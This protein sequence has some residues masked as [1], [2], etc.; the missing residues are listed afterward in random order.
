MNT[1]KILLILM[2]TTTVA[3]AATCPL[4]LNDEVDPE[5]TVTVLG[6]KL[7]FCCGS[8]VTK[9]EENTAYYIKVLEPLSKLFTEAEKKELKVCCVKPLDQ[10]YCP[11]YPDRLIN[12]NSP[13]VEYNGKKIYLW[14]SSAVRR[15]KRDPEKYYNS[16]LDSGIIK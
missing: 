9:F 6:K 13:V 7:E 14:S 10:R 5:E 12:P 4:M 15:W 16:G 1:K 8:C 2:C 11:V 3:A